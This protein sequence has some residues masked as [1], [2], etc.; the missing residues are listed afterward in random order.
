MIHRQDVERYPGSLVELAED[1]G[2][3]RYDALAE[4]LHALSKKLRVDGDA[5]EARGRPKLARGLHEAGT[6]LGE[7]AKKIEEAWTICEPP[8]RSPMNE[9]LE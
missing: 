3:L 9:K 6:A 8:M 7:S 2:N 1:L 4:F 5:D